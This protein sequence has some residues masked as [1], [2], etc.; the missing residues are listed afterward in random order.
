MVGWGIIASDIV[1]ITFRAV[2]KY[3]TLAHP[4]DRF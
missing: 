2:S 1:I 4:E 3:N